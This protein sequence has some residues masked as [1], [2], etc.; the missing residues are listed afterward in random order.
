MSKS[1]KTHGDQNI[2]QLHSHKEQIIWPLIVCSRF[3]F[4][5][6]LSE[7]TFEDHE[8]VVEPLLA[9]TR[10]SENKILFQER[11]EKNEVFKNP[12]VGR[13][14]ACTFYIPLWTYSEQSEVMC[15]CV[16]DCSNIK[17]GLVNFFLALVCTN[18]SPHCF[19]LSNIWLFSLLN[20]CLNDGMSFPHVGWPLTFMASL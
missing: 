1:K 15:V 6:L 8:N 3:K 14:I 20:R 9:W 5:F 17:L 10:D 11:P 18:P 7:R 16:C 13:L 19:Q 4:A 12:Q 2:Y